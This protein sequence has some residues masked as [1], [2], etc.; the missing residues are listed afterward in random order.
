M[1]EQSFQNIKILS[2]ADIDK[3]VDMDDAMDAMEAA[4]ASFSDGTSH[5]PQRHISGIKNLNL[6][7][8]PAFNEKLGRVSVKLITQRTA[9]KHPGIPTIQGLVLLIDMESGSILSMMDGAHITALRTG[10]AGGL[11]A[12]LLAPRHA[13]TVALFGCSAQG[14]TQL[15]AVCAVRQI[16]H[17]FLYDLNPD[18]ATKF[19]EEMEERL[20]ISTQITKD[21]EYLKKAQIICTATNAKHPL[22]QLKNISAGTHINAIGSYQPDMQEIDP[23]IIRSGK[24]FVDSR[25]SVLK[26]SGDLI[27]PINAGLFT[28]AV[29]EAEIG[30]LISK[31]AK[32]RRDPDEITIFKSVGLGVQDLFMANMIYEKYLQQ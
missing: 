19:K 29:I 26:E 30:E 1:S 13:E 31:K 9:G 22:F 28:A 10:A 20:G 11:A 27:K 2:S 4:F 17:A 16:K 24:I 25:E 15:E 7:F 8:K 12:K 6:F 23:A 18:A 32:G 21:P 14:K 5:V 3:L